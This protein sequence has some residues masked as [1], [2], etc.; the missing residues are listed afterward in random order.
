MLQI[1]VQNKEMLIAGN[2]KRFVY[3]A[4]AELQKKHAVA[5]QIYHRAPG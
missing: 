3:T 1:S 2:L 4:L 5:K